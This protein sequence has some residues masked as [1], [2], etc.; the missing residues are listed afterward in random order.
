MKEQNTLEAKELINST[1]DKVMTG[2]NIIDIKFRNGIEAQKNTME[3][4]G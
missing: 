4:F 2:Q 3:F 1:I